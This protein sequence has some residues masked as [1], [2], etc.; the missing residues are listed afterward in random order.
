MPLIVLHQFSPEA[1]FVLRVLSLP[2][3]VC[4]CIRMY[5]YHSLVCP[6]DNSGPV[7][8]RINKFGPTML[9]TLVKVSLVLRVIDLDLQGQIKLENR[10]LSHFE[11]VRT[12][13]HYPFKL[14]S[15]TLDQM[16]KTPCL[17]SQ[18]FWG[19]IALDL[20]VQIWLEKVKFSGFTTTGNA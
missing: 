8:A 11:L 12:I 6:H 1:S 15:P 20:Q 19:T 13:T 10:I 2:A 5:V 14:G 4:L 9:N 16:C 3:S 7:Q 17:R 18:S